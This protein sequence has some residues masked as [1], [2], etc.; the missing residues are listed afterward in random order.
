MVIG[1]RQIHHRADHNL[2]VDHHGALLDLVHAEN[3]GLRR[4]QDRGRHQRAVN[5]AVRNGEASASH[6]IRG[7][8]AVAGA[9]AEIGDLRFNLGKV[10]ATGI[11]DDRHDKALRR[12]DGDADIVIV[13]V[14]DVGAVDLGVDGREFL[15]RLDR[16]KNEHAHETKPGS[17]G[18]LEFLA[19]VGAHLHHRRHVDLVE[20]GQHRRRVL[21]RLEACRDDLAKLRHRHAF[22]AR[23]VLCPRLLARRGCHGCRCGR[24]W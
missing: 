4:I 14:N 17:V 3:A 18:G 21:G 20:G 11:A 22:L 5:A 19:V 1:Q 9:V 15:Q 6:V 2:V 23:R 10:H 24:L 8:L 13:L 7:Y 12:A 16:G